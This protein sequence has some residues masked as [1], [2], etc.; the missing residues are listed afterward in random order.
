MRKSLWLV[1][2]MLASV[3]LAVG[4]I[5]RTRRANVT[6]GIAKAELDLR[7]HLNVGASRAE[8]ESYLGQRG[9]EHTYVEHSTTLPEYS[10]T[11]FALIRETSRSRFVRGDIQILFT[12]DEHDKLVRYSLKEILTGP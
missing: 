7:A 4:I 5:Y 12:F 11:E 8:V 2:A 10:R 3:A 1:L 6:V 9:T